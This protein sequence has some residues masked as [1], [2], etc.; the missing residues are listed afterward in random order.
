MTVECPPPCFPKELVVKYDKIWYLR[1]FVLFKYL[2][3][4]E[5]GKKNKQTNEKKN[6]IHDIKTW[7]AE[8][9]MEYKTTKE[10]TG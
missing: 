2:E 3:T 6:K 4:F 1:F 10:K 7:H 5:K 9:T 8:A